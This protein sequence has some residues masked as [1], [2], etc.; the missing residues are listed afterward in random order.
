MSV[1]FK[2]K[3]P[4]ANIRA[5]RIHIISHSDNVM[6]IHLTGVTVYE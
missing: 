1:K 5:D 4:D 6:Q 2:Y 3:N